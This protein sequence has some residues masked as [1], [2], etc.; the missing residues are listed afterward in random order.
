M[1]D[2]EIKKN[3]KLLYG[4]L[5]KIFQESDEVVDFA[6]YKDGLFDDNSVKAMVCLMA[7]FKLINV[8]KHVVEYCIDCPD[9]PKKL[10]GAFYD[11]ISNEW[12]K[13]AN[14]EI[15]SVIKEFESVKD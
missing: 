7:Y 3:A 4:E 15:K 14:K 9:L 13:K 10:Y 12:L 2:K 6:L 8:Q 11:V 5:F 1:T